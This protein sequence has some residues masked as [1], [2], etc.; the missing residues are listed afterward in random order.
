[1]IDDLNSNHGIMEDN[2]DYEELFKEFDKE[3]AFD[4]IARRFYNRNFGTTTK[5]EI[6]LLMFSYYMDRTIQ[7]YKDANNRLDYTKCSNFSMAKRLGITPERVRTLKVKKQARYP[8]EFDWQE[9]LKA[10]QDNIRFD[11]NKIIIPIIDPNLLNEIRDYIE[12]KGGYVEIEASKSYLR[13][14][15]EYYCELMYYTMSI[16]DK[17]EF[18]N[19]LKKELKKHNKLDDSFEYTTKGDILG[20]INN[21]LSITGTGL[22]IIKNV[23]GYFSP[24]NKLASILFKVLSVPLQ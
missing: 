11:N 16:D 13:I 18:I 8:V 1:M 6:E 10:L 24:T 14:R 22:E 19:R 4:E 3:K 2:P 23:S 7:R 12:T 21:V 15:I 5:A 9:S 20:T 17:K